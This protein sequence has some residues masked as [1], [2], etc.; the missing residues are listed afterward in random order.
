MQT[1]WR[2]IQAG[3]AAV[4]AAAAITFGVPAEAQAAVGW[5]HF[6]GHDSVLDP[7]KGCHR[8]WAPEMTVVN[9]TDATV[10]FYGDVEC[11]TNATAIIHSGKQGPVRKLTQSYLVWR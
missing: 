7:P 4:G 8:M 6:S 3:A 5:L 10:S 1:T 11:F 2:R 9:N